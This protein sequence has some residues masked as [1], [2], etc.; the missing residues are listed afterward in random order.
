LKEYYEQM[1]SPHHRITAAQA[2]IVLSVVL[3][4]ACASDPQRTAPLPEDLE[5][6][7]TVL[8]LTELR[9]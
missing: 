6:Q 2:H 4:T 1:Y 7:T 9:N 3:L 5:A 8:G